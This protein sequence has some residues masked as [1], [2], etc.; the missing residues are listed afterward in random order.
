MSL[1]DWL[2]MT[3]KKHVKQWTLLFFLVLAGLVMG[4]FFI[5]PPH[6]EYHYDVYPG[7][8]AVFGFF[9]ALLMVI[10]MKKI[11]YPFIARPEDSSDDR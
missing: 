2:D 9:V 1:G 11:I 5:H 7:F 10:V 3:R 4:N 6:P 8:W